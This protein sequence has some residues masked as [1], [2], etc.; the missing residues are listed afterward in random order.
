MVV[1]G[2]QLLAV[3]ELVVL[4]LDGA[5]SVVRRADEDGVHP[6]GGLPMVSTGSSRR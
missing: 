1:V 3:L 5:S 4:V 2:R 6:A